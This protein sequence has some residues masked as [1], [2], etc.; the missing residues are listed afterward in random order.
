MDTSKAK[1]NE[2]PEK[3]I[4]VI[5]AA[6]ELLHAGSAETAQGNPALNLNIVLENNSRLFRGVIRDF[7]LNDFSAL[8]YEFDSLKLGDVG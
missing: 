8:H 3:Y 6:L 5:C 2:L 7:V 4:G 1:I